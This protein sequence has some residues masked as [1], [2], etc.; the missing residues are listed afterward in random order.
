[1]TAPLAPSLTDRTERVRNLSRSG[2]IV[3]KIGSAVLTDE[4]GR[5]DPKIIRRIASDV[6]PLANPKRWPTIV[7]SGAIAVGMGILRLSHRPQTMAGLQAAAAVGQSKLV[8]AW[9]QAFRKYELPVAQILLTHA[10]L[11]NRRRFL[12]ARRALGELEK[13]RSVAVINENDSVSFEEIAFGD[14]DELAAQVTNLIDAQLLIMLSSAPGVLD[15]QGQ[16][17]PSAEAS[18]PY[19]DDVAQPHTSR[20]GKGGMISKLRAARMACARGAHVAILP[21]RT[22]EILES[23]LAGDDVGTLLVPDSTQP[24]LNS[25]AHWIAHTLRANGVVMVDAGAADAL[26]HGGKSLLASGVTR[27]EG[28]FLEGDAVDITLTSSAQ[29]AFARGLIRYSAEHMRQI[30]GGSSSDIP[31]TL[32]FSAGDAVIHRDD[33]V[34]LSTSLNESDELEIRATDVEI[35]GKA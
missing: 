35:T 3:V 13:R 20:V 10:D 8:E 26:V 17:I 24:S 18:H 9:A 23:F 1:M 12:N 28:S 33:L 31:E 21:G 16:R 25:R 32:G 14:N 29:S 11:A 27:I 4:Q 15:H 5:L 22:P 19:L 2:R 30:I 6:A 7:S 34:V